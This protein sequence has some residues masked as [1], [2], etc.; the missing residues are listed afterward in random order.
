M[1]KPLKHSPLMFM[2]AHVCGEARRH[3]PA[4][5]AHDFIIR[6]I[7]PFYKKNKTVFVCVKQSCMSRRAGATVSLYLEDKWPTYI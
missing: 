3:T 5:N 1:G 6:Y 4:L 2:L 7:I